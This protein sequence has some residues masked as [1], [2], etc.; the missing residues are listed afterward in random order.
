MTVQPIVRIYGARAG[1]ILPRMLEQIRQCRESGGKIMLL[2]PEQYTLQAERELLRGLNL[3]GLMDMDVI[4]PRKLTQLVQEKG[5]RSALPPLSDQGRRMALSHALGQLSGQ[6]HYY[7]SVADTPGLPDKISSLLSDFQRAGV[8][9]EDLARYADQLP[10]GAQKEKLTDL[11]AIWGKYEQVIDGR[12]AD[13]TAVEMDL[14]RRL[15]SSAVFEDVSLWVYGF[16]VLPRPMCLMLTEAA[17]TARQITVSLVM[18]A[19]DAPDGRIFLGQRRSAGE[20]SD[21]LTEAGITFEMRYLPHLD[22]GRAPALSH[23]ETWLFTRQTPPFSG[24]CEGVHIHAAANPYS[25]AAYAATM[26]KSWHEAGIPWKRMAVALGISGGL[27]GMMAVT[28][29]AAGIPHY[30]A[31]KDVAA[32]HGLC[33]LLLGAL[34]ASTKGYARDDV[35]DMAKSGFSPLTIREAHHLENYAIENGITRGKWQKPFT[36]GD[37]AA[38]MEPLRQRL[39]AP[40]I[41]LHDD[42]VAASCADQS[43]EAVMAFLTAVNAYDNLILREEELLRRGMMAEAS[44]NRQVWQILMGLMD[45]LHTLLGDKR[46]TLK[47]MARFVEAGLTSTAISALPPQADCVMVGQAGHLMTGDVDALLLMGMQDGVLGAQTDSLI[48]DEERLHLSDAMHRAIGLSRY[49]QAAL[50]QSDFYRTISLPRKHLTLTYSQGSQDGAALRPAGLIGEI[51]ALLPEVTVS[52]GVTAD[53]SAAGP[54]SPMLALDGLALR[55]RQLADGLLSDMEDSWQDSLRWLWRHPQWHT[56]MAQVVESL[57]AHTNHALLPPLETRRLFGGEQVSITRLESFA[58]CP[59]Q[60]FVS[61][62]LKPVPRREFTFESDEKGNFFHAALQQ[63][64]TLASTEPDWPRIPQERVDEMMDTVLA[65]LQ[66]EWQGGP[67]EEDAMGRQLGKSYL[68]TIR[69]AAWL[70]TRHAANSHFTT[71]G[72][73]VAFGEEGGL[74]PVILT[75]HD[76]QKVALRGKIDRIDRWE[77]DKG[78]YLRVVDYKSS[79]RSLNATRMWYGLQLQLMLYLQAASQVRDNTHPAGAFYFT[80]QDPLVKSDEDIKEAAEDLIAKELRLSGVVLAD[81]EVVRAM[82]S[83]IPEFSI[84]KVLNRDGSI[85]AHAQAYSMEEMHALLGHAKQTAADLADA[86]RAGQIAVS[87][88]EIGTKWSACTWCEYR[89]VCQLDPALPGAQKRVLC[90]LSRQELAD[91]LTNQSL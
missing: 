48:S 50:R 1:Q 69:R 5:G 79:S 81:S 53:E 70:F 85:A 87:P 30:I 55:L 88:A 17:R 65:P 4:S 3:P 29:Q 62:G 13:E 2:V 46:A 22:T 64:A 32:R 68:R 27:D 35:L 9:P 77:G 51:R 72:T 15:K 61:Y 56:R 14:I 49:E 21:C 36:R 34:R 67:L 8:T 37:K 25:E 78:I 19:K 39:M 60:H 11:S 26:L 89:S 86:I 45:Q 58:A 23:L 7:G 91:R 38:D 59:Y 74:P 75:L 18:D 12:F 40:V 66:Q 43:V 33:R 54:L 57:S 16:D 52:G 24:P 83:D 41:Q 73:E 76:G 10:N 31:R 20:L 63:Y 47:E 80:V 84:G 42:L 6:L 44:Q 71:W 82:D 90:E 28:L